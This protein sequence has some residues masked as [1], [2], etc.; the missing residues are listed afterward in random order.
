MIEIIVT[1]HVYVE[2]DDQM[3]QNKEVPLTLE[4]RAAVTP[5]DAEP[6]SFGRWEMLQL[7]PR[8]RHVG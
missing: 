7:L 2:E 4:T 8:S 6:K 5:D 3:F 1:I